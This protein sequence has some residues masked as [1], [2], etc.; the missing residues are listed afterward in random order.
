MWNK[1]IL[2]QREGEPVQEFASR[3]RSWFDE[4]VKCRDVCR[5]LYFFL[6]LQPTAYNC[7]SPFKFGDMLACLRQLDDMRC[8]QRENESMSAY[9]TRIS[10][11]FDAARSD[12]D[13]CFVSCVVNG[14]REYDEQEKTYLMY[15][16][17]R[18]LCSFLQGNT[19]QYMCDITEP[20]EMEDFLRKYTQ[21]VV[22]KTLRESAQL[23]AANISPAAPPTS[24]ESPSPPSPPPSPPSI[25]QTQ[26]DSSSMITDCE[27]H[28]DEDPI[29]PISIPSFAD[30]FPD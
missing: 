21:S 20:I 7:V 12:C 3:V 2:Y 30:L 17:R 6:G 23:H 9:V 14:L 25:S 11:I 15:E 8:K 13:L 1:L 22:D 18:G 27:P 5:Y 19:V 4:K 24:P 10:N 28:V 16:T 29:S 26:P